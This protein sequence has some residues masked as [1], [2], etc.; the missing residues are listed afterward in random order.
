MT[1]RVTVE[2]VPYGDQDKAYKLGQ[3]LISNLGTG[4]GGT[5]RYIATLYQP[6]VA[7]NPDGHQTAF[8]NNF[9]HHRETGWGLCVVKAILAV[10]HD[11]KK[12]ET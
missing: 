6:R 1:L 4:S 12:E 3:L 5:H 7:S 2:R 8:N 10:Q 11:I 9:Y